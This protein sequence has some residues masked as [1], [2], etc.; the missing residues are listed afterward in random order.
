MSPEGLSRVETE[1]GHTKVEPTDG[2]I[3]GTKIAATR[4]NSPYP[5]PTQNVQKDEVL[6]EHEQSSGEEGMLNNPDEEI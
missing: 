1:K 4:N 2:P 6:R 5:S 3:K